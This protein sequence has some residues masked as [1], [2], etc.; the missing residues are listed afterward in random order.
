M[1]VDPPDGLP[2]ECLGVSQLPHSIDVVEL[3]PRPAGGV[4][5]LRYVVEEEN[6]N[7]P[8]PRPL[9]VGIGPA[10]NIGRAVLVEPGRADAVNPRVDYHERRLDLLE[11]LLELRRCIV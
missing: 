6:R 9:W 8:H 11:Q 4:A 2:V 10:C 3:A 7:T 1:H 5:L